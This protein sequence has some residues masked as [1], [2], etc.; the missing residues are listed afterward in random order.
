MKSITFRLDDE[1]KDILQQF[2]EKNDVSI[3]WVVRKAIKDFI[4]NNQRSENNGE[5]NYLL[6]ESNG[7]VSETG[8]YPSSD[9]TE[10]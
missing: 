8:S 1:E 2:A 5:R 9:S 6:I 10:S 3:S 7:I 4:A